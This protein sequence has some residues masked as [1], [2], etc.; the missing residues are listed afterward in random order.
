MFHSIIIKWPI[1]T[2]ARLSQYGSRSVKPQGPS[3]IKTRSTRLRAGETIRRVSKSDKITER[4]TWPKT[5]TINAVIKWHRVPRETERKWTKDNGKA[6]I[7]N[8]EAQEEYRQTIKG[9]Y[10]D[11]DWVEKCIERKRNYDEYE[12]IGE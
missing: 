11:A 12:E 4:G 10:P 9:K 2:L 3:S 5:N 8:R 6:I 1:Q 7:R